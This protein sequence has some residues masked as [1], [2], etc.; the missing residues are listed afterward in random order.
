[1]K[2]LSIVIPS[3]KEKYLQKTIDDL[4]AKAEGSIEI[5][6]VLDAYWPDPPLKK[7]DNLV[8]VHHGAGEK[9]KGMRQSINAGM[10]VA[11]GKYLMKTDGHCMF[12]KGFDRKLIAN[13]EENWLVIPRR[14]RLDPE[15]W[16]IAPDVRPPID[17]HFLT[18]PYTKTHNPN[19][20]LHGNEWRKRYFERQ[21]ILIDDNMSAQG[22]CYFTTRKWWFKMIHPMNE[23]LYGSFTS[24]AQ[25][26]C[27]NTWL[28][29][30][31]VVVNKNTWYAHWYKGSHGKGYDFSRKKHEEYQKEREAGNKNCTDYWL[32]NK[33]PKK[34]HGFE[35]LI[36][37]FWPVPTWPKNWKEE[38]TKRKVEE[39]R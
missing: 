9:N 20:G 25:E 24:E 22:S 39:K 16:A 19:N 26:I 4:I 15:K 38:I 6:V 28:G 2:D 33:F 36:E 31:R 23:A 5:V 8:V 14:Y 17:Y 11:K 12:D 29:G 27:N 3:R 21:E 32:N 34:V 1:M 35:W 10:E 37:K 7:Y 13:C 30:G 18:Y